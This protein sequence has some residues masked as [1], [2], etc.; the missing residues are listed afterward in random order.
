M[1]RR[2]HALAG[3]GVLAVVVVAAAASPDAALGTLAWLAT[4]PIRFGVALI[5]LAVIRPLL[6]WPT[7][8]LALAVGYG[9]GVGGLPVAL[10]LIVG[11]SVPPYLLARRLTGGGRVA[12]AGKRFVDTTGGVR[13]VAASRLVP[14]PSDVVSVGAG[15]AGVRLGSFLVGTAIGELPWAVVGVLAG[16]SLETLS[17]GTLAQVADPRLAVALALAGVLLLAGPLYRHVRGRSM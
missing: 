11:T 6:V 4:D 1:N 16:D 14:A 8:L 3:L 7:T 15:I 17:T 10:A 12:A 13:S 2:R 5:V 9:Y